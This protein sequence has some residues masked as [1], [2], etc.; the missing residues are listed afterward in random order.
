[1]RFVSSGS[2]DVK[3]RWQEFCQNNIIEIAMTEEEERAEDERK[4]V[5]AAITQGKGPHFLALTPE[6]FDR[7]VASDIPTLVDFWAAWCQPCL[8]MVSV[9]ERYQNGA[10][11]AVTVA[12][13]DIEA[14]E[15]LWQR[16]GLKGIPTLI[17]FRS[18]VEVGRIL[19][20]RTL[21]ELQSE[22]A[23]LLA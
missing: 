6:T 8:Q 4:R 21:E 17:V 18:G 20:T 5:A 14:H 12:S 9:L 1:M 3:A 19:G 11:G 23:G 13:V 2:N 10:A 15:S 16:F 7:T 22:L